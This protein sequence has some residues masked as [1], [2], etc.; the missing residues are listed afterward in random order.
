MIEIMRSAKMRAPMIM[1]M[2]LMP[3]P[4]PTNYTE[5]VDISSL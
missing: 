3:W 1:T 4:V 2:M 5:T